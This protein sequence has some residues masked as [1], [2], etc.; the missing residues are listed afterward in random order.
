M[1]VALFCLDGEYIKVIVLLLRSTGR[2]D[3]SRQ[4]AGTLDSGF[5]KIGRYPPAASRTLKVSGVIHSQVP[6]KYLSYLAR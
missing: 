5:R 4:K 3:L 2:G 1:Q 6:H